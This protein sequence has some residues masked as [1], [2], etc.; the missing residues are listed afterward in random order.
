MAG[1]LADQ[2]DYLHY[3]KSY[4]YDLRTLTST[5]NIDRYNTSLITLRIILKFI[6]IKYNNNEVKIIYHVILF[7]YNQIVL[8]KLAF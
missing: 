1:R 5:K 7:C 6:Y 8:I 2:C 3:L 4:Y